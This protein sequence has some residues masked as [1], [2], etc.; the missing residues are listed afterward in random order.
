MMVACADHPHEARP[1]TGPCYAANADSREQIP[2]TAPEKL[3]PSNIFKLGYMYPEDLRR[4]HLQGRV[5]VRLK[6]AKTGK[7]NSAELLS[8]E[9]PT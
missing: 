1:L 3:P 8:V 7:I 4:Q 9:A 6:V 5:L 2:T